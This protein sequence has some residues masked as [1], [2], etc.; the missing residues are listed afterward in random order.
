MELFLFMS[1]TRMLHVPYKGPAQAIIDLTA[2]RVA[3][4]ML[5]MINSVPHVRA[6]RLR[7]LGVTGSKRAVGMPDIPTIAEAGLGGYESVQWTGL[8]APAGTPPDIIA[9]L[10]KEVTA[11]LN[12]EDMRERL[13]RQDV[14]ITAGSPEDFAGYI[15]AETIKWARV[16]KSAG[17]QPE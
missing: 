15:R 7:A 13:A 11:V 6:G 4:Q 17:I 3:V 2:G 10:N 14:E 9:R 12:A 1:G 16:A 5:G 8:L